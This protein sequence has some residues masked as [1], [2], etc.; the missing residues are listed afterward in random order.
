MAN[1]KINWESLDEKVM[2]LL[3]QGKS[4][5]EIA[6]IIGVG[7]AT[8][9]RWHRRNRNRCEAIGIDAYRPATKVQGRRHAFKGELSVG[10][11]IYNYRTDEKCEV[12]KKYE[13][14]FLCLSDRGNRVA[15]SYND[16]VDI[17]ILR[18]NE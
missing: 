12:L 1:R 11:K 15:F 7:Y 9:L 4:F 10:D 14:I 3:Q 18:K 16:F 5:K 13:H 2:T 8:M 17:K 6:D